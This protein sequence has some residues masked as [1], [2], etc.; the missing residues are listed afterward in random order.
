MVGLRILLVSGEVV[1]EGGVDHPVARMCPC[2]EAASVGQLAAMHLHIQ[3]RQRACSL[4]VSRQPEHL[5]P[6]REQ[7]LDDRGAD[8]A[9]GSGYEYTQD[10][11]LGLR[12]ST[13]GGAG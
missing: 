6:R 10:H 2:G 11:L 7:F 1:D 4:L 9:R 13:G 5:V 3:P 12:T 8:E